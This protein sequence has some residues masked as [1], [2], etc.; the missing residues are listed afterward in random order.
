M[1]ATNCAQAYDMALSERQEHDLEEGGWKFGKRLTTEHVWDAFVL[2]SLIL[3]HKEHDEIVEVPHFGEQ[4]TRFIQLMKR[5][6]AFVITDGQEE[7]PHYCDKC[8]RVWKSDD[9]SLHKF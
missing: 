6:N 8:M 1:S 9:G 3:Q 4:K 7:V 5:R 2:W